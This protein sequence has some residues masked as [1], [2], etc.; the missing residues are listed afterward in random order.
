MQNTSEKLTFGHNVWVSDR[1]DIY[2]AMSGFLN[3]Q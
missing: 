1:E 2:L 3:F